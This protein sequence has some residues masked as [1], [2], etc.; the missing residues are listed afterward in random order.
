M[1]VDREQELAGVFATL[2]ESFRRDY[3]I[4][5]A[6]HVL[7]DASVNFTSAT[8]AGVVLADATQRLHVI[9]S[10]SERGS[11]VEEA[12][13]DSSAGPSCEAFT[14]GESVAVP[15]I[16]DAQSRWP[17]FAAIAPARG[18]CSAHAVPLLSDGRCF[19]SVTV[20]S[21]QCVALDARDTAILQAFVAVA[22]TG[23]V[24]HRTIQ[25]QGEV[26]AQLQQALDS[27][28]LIEQAK[29]VIAERNNVSIDLAFDLLRL[30]SR[31]T[32]T[33]LHDLARQVVSQHFLL[34]LH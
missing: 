11:A 18:L 9:A 31:S 21:D 8:E 23:I 27:R 15:D 5:D 24:Q 14:T 34:P 33:S 32:N 20:F 4:V 28:T 6:M 10:T 3:E 12:Q 19:G 17:H 25:K 7:V 2:A 1:G 13:L 16:T 29:G 30:H 22:S 26:S